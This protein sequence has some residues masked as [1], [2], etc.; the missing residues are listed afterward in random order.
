MF[1]VGYVSHDVYFFFALWGGG[2]VLRSGAEFYNCRYPAISLI[3]PE[4]ARGRL[5]I[6]NSPLLVTG[7]SRCLPQRIALP[8]ASRL[9]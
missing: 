4:S 6:A 3:E 1:S 8:R 7:V 2:I 9:T 5:L